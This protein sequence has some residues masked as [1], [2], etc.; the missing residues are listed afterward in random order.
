MSVLILRIPEHGCVKLS[1]KSLKSVVKLS[2]TLNHRASTLRASVS[3][4]MWRKHPCRWVFWSTE[5]RVCG[6]L[7]FG[8]ASRFVCRHEL[9]NTTLALLAFGCSE[10]TNSS[11]SEM[12]V[13]CIRGFQAHLTVW[14]VLP[15]VVSSIPPSRFTKRKPLCAEPT[16]SLQRSRF[17]QA[18]AVSPGSRTE[19]GGR[20]PGT[21]PRV[22]LGVGSTPWPA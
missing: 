10:L 1:A 7:G 20:G 2:A 5:W 22:L 15:H 3:H 16:P 9:V 21:G 6:G 17:V 18:E 14:V 13:L 4:N 12:A 19:S 11:G 8:V